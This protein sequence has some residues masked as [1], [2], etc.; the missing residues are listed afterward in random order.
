MSPAIIPFVLELL[1]GPAPQSAASPAGPALPAGTEAQAEAVVDYP[2]GPMGVPDFS[3][4]GDPFKLVDLR[5]HLIDTESTTHAFAARV[6]VLGRGYLGASFEGERRDVSWTS[7][8]LELRASGEEGVY[9]LFGSWR[10][11][12]LI[13]SAAAQ[14]GGD[15]EGT[16][17]LLT[18]SLTVRVSPELEAYAWALG[19]T[20]EPDDRFLRAAYF[21]FL[22][23]RGA[24]LEAAGEIGRT[25]EVVEAGFENQRD[26]AFLSA[27]GQLGGAEIGGEA[28]YEDVDGRFPRQVEGGSARA[29]VP[30]A[31][32]LVVQ[33]G[34]TVR[35]ETSA[36]LRAYDVRGGLAW[37]GRRYRPPR[38]GEAAERALALARRATSLGANERFVVGDE[39]RRAQ[40]ERLSL[41]PQRDEL[42]GDMEAVY[43]AQVA[44]RQVP[45]LGVEVAG[46]ED[47]LPGLTTRS[48]RAFVGVPWPPAWPWQANESAVPFLRLDL[49]RSRETSGTGFV[50]VTWA[51]S[52]A[53]SLNREMDL[54]LR[55]SRSDPTALDLIRGVGRRRTIE[56]AYVYAFGR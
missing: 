44:E 15:A 52:L 8:R 12:R 36:G 34:T 35:F 29:V 56:I 19:N 54:V 5:Y 1:S 47:T 27:V 20:Q 17:W 49:A 3:S 13:V 4:P 41:S 38:A 51:S 43:R 45:L 39:E 7:Q 28:W 14:T 18:P 37:Y 10:A 16:G 50:A 31:A 30:L 46:S 42:Y 32:R 25:Y 23:Q 33:G 6:K 53:V 11:P 40:R 21:G 9:G 2:L 26:S 55:W 24:R 22:W 48:V